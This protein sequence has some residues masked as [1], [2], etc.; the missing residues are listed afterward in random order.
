[1]LLGWLGRDV[2]LFDQ[3]NGSL[4][5]LQQQQENGASLVS[6]GGSD[7]SC[8]HGSEKGLVRSERACSKTPQHGL[9]HKRGG[10]T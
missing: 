3:F 9:R 10:H 6:N 8:A 7:T 4:H 5:L 1:M 2:D